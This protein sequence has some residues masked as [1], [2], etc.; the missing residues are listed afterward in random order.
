MLFLL[1]DVKSRLFNNFTSLQFLKI[2]KN[3]FFRIISHQKHV[4]DTLATFFF[5]KEKIREKVRV[6]KLF[7][8]KEVVLGGKNFTMTFSKHKTVSS[9]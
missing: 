1:I 4:K 9:G 3:T 7:C 2:P 5:A 6:S 8:I